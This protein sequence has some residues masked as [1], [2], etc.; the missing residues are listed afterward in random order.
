MKLSTD[1]WKAAY[2]KALTDLQ[3][4]NPTI[5]AS[6]GVVCAVASLRVIRDELKASLPADKDEE[7]T[8]AD[9]EELVH[10]QFGELITQLSGSGA[11]K[12][13]GFASNA[14]SA[15]AACGLKVAAISAVAQGLAD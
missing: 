7:L 6:D 8:V 4:L 10:K 3:K 5:G 9:V 12:L 11:P 1:K 15:A 2:P 13:A 14:S